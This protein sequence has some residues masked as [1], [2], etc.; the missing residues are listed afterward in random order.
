MYWCTIK[1]QSLLFNWHPSAYNSHR[2]K[3]P[4]SIFEKLGWMY[5]YTLKMQSS[6]IKDYTFIFLC[7]SALSQLY[8][9]SWPKLISSLTDS[10]SDIHYIVLQRY[11]ISSSGMLIFSLIDLSAQTFQLGSR[12]HQL[13]IFASRFKHLIQFCIQI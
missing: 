1:I 6:L 10:K 11:Q 2:I 7:L 8:C 4:K 3:N 9:I 5:W 13:S 12:L